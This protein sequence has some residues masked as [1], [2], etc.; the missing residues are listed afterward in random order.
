MAQ[1]KVSQHAR[2][3]QAQARSGITHRAVGDPNRIIQYGKRYVDTETGNYVY[4]DGER[5]LIVDKNGVLVS[6]FRNTRANTLE[7]L[8]NGRWLSAENDENVQSD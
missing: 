8:R 2:H 5:V 4:V 1:K 6:Q 7:R 3:R